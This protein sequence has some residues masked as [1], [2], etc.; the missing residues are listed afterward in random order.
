MSEKDYDPTEELGKI[1]KVAARIKRV[2]DSEGMPSRLDSELLATAIES[3]DTYI[4]YGG[5]LPDQWDP[6]YECGPEI[7]NADRRC[8]RHGKV[9]PL[10]RPA[11][12]AD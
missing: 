2:I 3:L 1:R 10:R 7:V 12:A 5:D 8:L 9:V 4:S 11:S 6:C